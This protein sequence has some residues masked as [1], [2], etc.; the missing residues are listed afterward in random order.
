MEPQSQPPSPARAMS[1]HRIEALT[2]GVYA[3]AITLLVLDLRVPHTIDVTN[4]H[5][6]LVELAK[7]FPNFVAW[8]ISFFVL[9]I[10]WYAQ[11]RLFQWLK[12]TDGRLNWLIIVSLLFVCFLPFASSL[13]GQFA[14]MFAA[15][16]VYAATMVGMALASMSIVRHIWRHPELCH[17]PMPR[18]HY[19]AAMFRSFGIIV[20]AGTALGIAFWKPLFATFAFMLM[21]V[22]T[23]ISRRIE[24]QTVTAKKD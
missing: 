17:D 3:I 18:G 23:G 4:E 12:A 9:A 19:V 14:G 13:T 7:L 8:L 2:D 22:F 21:I 1:K 20:S 24:R 11:N 5:E 16:A 10:F 6:L 15:Q